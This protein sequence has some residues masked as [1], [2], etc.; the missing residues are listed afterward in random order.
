MI[1]GWSV[2]TVVYRGKEDRLS[3]IP[4]VP[5]SIRADTRTKIVPLLMIAVASDIAAVAFAF[6]GATTKELFKDGHW[7]QTQKSI[8]VRVIPGRPGADGT[9][10]SRPK[11]NGYW[12]CISLTWRYFVVGYFRKS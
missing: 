5:D 12:D 10:A 2:F 7:F 8:T 4:D 6:G 9:L 1:A 11:G 3:N